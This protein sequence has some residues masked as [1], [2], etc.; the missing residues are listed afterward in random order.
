MTI[1]HIYLRTYWRSVSKAEDHDMTF[2][3]TV[4]V[5]FTCSW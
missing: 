5:H 3:N 4:V 2:I 1:G